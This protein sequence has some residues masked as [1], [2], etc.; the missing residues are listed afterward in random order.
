MKNDVH[1]DLDMCIIYLKTDKYYNFM[2]ENN[3]RC[4]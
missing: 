1:I 2:K 3:N 4:H